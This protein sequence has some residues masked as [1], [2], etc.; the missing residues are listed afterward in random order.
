[1]FFIILESVPGLVDVI[2]VT[3]YLH[4]SIF[5]YLSLHADTCTM[6]ASCGAVESLMKFHNASLIPPQEFKWTF[7]VNDLKNRYEQ[8]V[9]K[10]LQSENKVD[11]GRRRLRA[12]LKSFKEY[13]VK[14]TNESGTEVRYDF[15]SFNQPWTVLISQKLGINLLQNFP[16]HICAT[17]TNQCHRM[18]C[19]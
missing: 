18:V 17:K 9:G 8:S 16:W 4:L 13:G 12:V 10:L 5:V 14:A 7:I 2:L 6:Q 15:T 1:M 11:R 3:Q 19:D